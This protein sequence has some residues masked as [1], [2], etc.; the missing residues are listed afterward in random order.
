M[1][2]TIYRAAVA[3][4]AVGLIGGLFYR[5]FTK[6]QG[7]DGGTQLALLHTHAL[8]L[9]TMTMLILLALVAT[10]RID[11]FKNFTAGF[12]TYTAGAALTS[13]MLTV[14]GSL[15]VLGS[16]AADSPAIAG[17]SGLGHITITL[18]LILLLMAIGAAV[19]QASAGS[20]TSAPTLSPVSASDER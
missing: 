3:W 14:K 16:A 12:W 11:E 5:E 17:I 1:L 10:L 20:A 15:Q 4:T 7:V 8:T 18:G 13:I 19:K 2:K 6:A 9:G